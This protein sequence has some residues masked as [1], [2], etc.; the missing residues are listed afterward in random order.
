MAVVK[1]T[2]LIIVEDLVCLLNGLEFDF[3]SRALVFGDLVWV[4]GESS[5]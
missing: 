2:L 5:L 1:F 4:T 3:G